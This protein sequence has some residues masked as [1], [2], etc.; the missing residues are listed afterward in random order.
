MWVDAQRVHPV[1]KCFLFSGLSWKDTQRSVKENSLSSQLTD[2]S[3]LQ[4]YGCCN[5][6]TFILCVFLWHHYM[7]SHVMVQ[8]LTLNVCVLHGP[9]KTVQARTHVEHVGDEGHVEL[10]VSGR[11]V[12][13]GDELPA[14]EPRRLPQHQLGPVGQVLLLCRQTDKR[15]YVHL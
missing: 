12:A 2:A 8:Q 15:Q 6:E 10:A 11:D 3:T 1:P 14:V 7:F 4:I 5:L 9:C 13:S